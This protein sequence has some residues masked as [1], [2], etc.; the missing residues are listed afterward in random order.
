[1]KFTGIA[2]MNFYMLS[3]ADKPAHA[4]RRHDVSRGLRFRVATIVVVAEVLI[5]HVRSISVVSLPQQVRYAERS[6]RLS[7]LLTTVY[8]RAVSD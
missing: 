1:M 5:H 6:K 4:R 7:R 3:H 2:W 8:R